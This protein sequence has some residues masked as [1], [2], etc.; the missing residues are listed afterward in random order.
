MR[1]FPDSSW[2]DRSK[3]PMPADRVAA[4]PWL[5]AGRLLFAPFPN[6]DTGP[7]SRE[8][9]AIE[10]MATRLQRDRHAGLLPDSTAFWFSPI[11]GR[12]TPLT[13]NQVWLRARVMQHVVVDLRLIE[14]MGRIVPLTLL[15]PP[16]E[17][18]RRVPK[19]RRAAIEA[20][21]AA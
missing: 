19:A 12:T 2:S 13:A 7:T 21:V 9:E 11:D 6:R 5:I 14:A 20:V 10:A 8:I 18:V 4:Q 17:L 3:A 16:P 1:A 15:P